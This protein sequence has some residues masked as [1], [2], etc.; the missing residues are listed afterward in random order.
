MEIVSEPHICGFGN[1][2]TSLAILVNLLQV[3]LPRSIARGN[4]LFIVIC[5]AT[6]Y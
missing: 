4:L 1:L 6:N 2:I 3:S 5:L